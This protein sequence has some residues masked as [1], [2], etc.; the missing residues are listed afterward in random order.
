MYTITFDRPEVWIS[1]SE[2]EFRSKMHGFMNEVLEEWSA[3]EE[4]SVLGAEDVLN[5]DVFN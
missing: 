4:E 3:E 1:L 2:D 5:Q